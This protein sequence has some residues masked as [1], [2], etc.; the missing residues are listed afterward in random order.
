TAD[1]PLKG[2]RLMWLCSMF[3]RR[4]PRTAPAR[5]KPA[6]TR[7]TVEALESRCVLSTLNLTPLVQVSEPDPF[8]AG[9][10]PGSPFTNVEAEPQLA[11][12]PTNSRHLVGVWNEDGIGMVAGVSFNGGESWRQV[13]IP[14]ITVCSG[15][16]WPHEGDPWVSFAPNGDVYV[17]ALGLDATVEP[18]AVLVNKSTDGGLTWSA[19]TTIVQGNSDDHD[20]DSVT[21][22]PTN[23]QFAYATWTRFSSARGATM[24][25]RTTDGGQTWEPARA[26]LD[27]GG[28][29]INQAHQIVV[30]A[31]GTLVNFFSQILFENQA[32][33]T[34]HVELNL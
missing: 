17:S 34:S 2:D 28:K 19:P 32:G 29:N 15:G 8:P 22:D 7:L 20:K 26:I 31:D 23:S 3:D 13:V 6:S 30:L 11:V 16:I 25:S 9:C 12:D 14:G 18:K 21:A 1:R 4:R 5:R 33:G 24:F 10:L 27:P